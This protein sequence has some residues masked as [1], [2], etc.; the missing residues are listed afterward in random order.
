MARNSA[1]TASARSMS[2]PGIV[3]QC[4]TSDTDL[5]VGLF[6]TVESPAG[7]HITPG[8]R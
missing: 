2:F 5:I 4:L 1:K 7:I 3:A 8:C 6:R